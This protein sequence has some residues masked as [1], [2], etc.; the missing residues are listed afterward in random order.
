MEEIKLNRRNVKELMDRDYI[1]K[2]FVDT[3]TDNWFWVKIE[4]DGK[5]NH[6]KKLKKFK[7]L[8]K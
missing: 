5:I 8:K 6:F 1:F 4:R 2:I 7:N 3:E